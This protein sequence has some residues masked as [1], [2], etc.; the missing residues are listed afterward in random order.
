MHHGKQYSRSFVPF[1]LAATVT[2][3]RPIVADELPSAPVEQQELTVWGLRPTTAPGTA[4]MTVSARDADEA[5]ARDIGEL[6][7]STVPGVSAHKL[8]A[9]HADPVLRGTRAERVGVTVDGAPIHGACPSRMDPETSLLDVAE[10][11]AVEVVKGPYAV[12]RGP[13]GIG[14]TIAIETRDPLLTPSFSTQASALGG[15]TSNHDGWTARGSASA[16]GPRAAVRVGGSWREFGDYT[17]GGGERVPSGFEDRAA[18]GVLLWQPTPDHRLRLSTN[19]SWLRDARFASASMDTAEEDSYLGSAS[20]TRHEPISGFED[21]TL[22]SYYSHIDHL[23]DN[24]NKPGAHTMRMWAPLSADTYGG[25]IQATTSGRGAFKLSFGGDTYRIEH[26]GSRHME[27]LSGPMAGMVMTSTVWPDT[28]LF[29]GGMFA[30]LTYAPGGPLHAVVG[31]R[32]DLLD[33]G[34]HPD[35]AARAAFVR[36]YGRGADDTSAL[37]VNTS[38]NGRLIYSPTDTVDLFA[39]LGRGVRTASPTE[40]FFVFGPGRGG[41]LVGNPSLEPESSLEADIGVTGHWRGLS[42]NGSF[43]YNRLDNYIVPV[44]LARTDV[45]MDGQPDLVRGFNNAAAVLTGTDWGATYAVSAGLSVFGSLAYVYGQNER[46]DRPLPEIPPLEGSLGLRWEHRWVETGEGGWWSW[47]MPRVRLANRQNR[48]DNDFGENTSPAF[49][50]VDFL[51]GVRVYR[52]YEL[53]LNVMNILDR[54]YRQ[55]LTRENPFT[56]AEVPEPGRLVNLALQVRL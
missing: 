49:A 37:E 10:V 38:V 41:Y 6:L 48:V 50:T 46:T 5:L 30:E 11:G 1:L 39:G 16:S 42:L 55:H 14:G 13:A 4:G 47:C 54:N 24:A 34:A 23:M 33:A 53:T 21:F 7:H 27:Q 8:G 9:A 25:R 44:L 35:A 40:R 19:A 43:F 17:S 15:Y 56:G 26:A 22:S 12:T 52:R 45:N 29:D 36:H 51:G 2:I 28:H 20:Y 3:P 31:A 18:S 32:V